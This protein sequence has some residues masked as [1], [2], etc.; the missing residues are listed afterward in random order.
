MGDRRR[1]RTSPPLQRI[2]IVRLGSLGD[3][4]HTLPAAAALREAWPEARLDWVVD[5]RQR[6][7]LELVPILDRRIVLRGRS[8]RDW[9]AAAVALRRGRYDVAIDFQGLLKSALLAR[10]SGARRVVGFPLRHLRERSARVFYSRTFRPGPG[11]VIE[12]NLAL[13]RGLGRREPGNWRTGELGKWFPLRVPGETREDL[14]WH[15]LGFGAD[16]PYALLNPGAAWPNKRW[17]PDRFAGLAA[18]LRSRQALRSVVMWGP[19]E[20]SLARAVA[21]ASDGA[22]AIAPRTNMADLVR[23]ARGA[24]VLVSGDTGPL[25]VAAAVGT[26][27]VGIYGPTDPARNGP[28]Q[29]RDQTLSRVAECQCVHR[30]RCRARVWCLEDA[31]IEDVY[32]LV[33]RRLAAV[34]ADGGA[35]GPP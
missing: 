7:I 8:P 18:R 26:P 19:G 1:V 13:V 14:H 12:K 33:E 24:A 15:R 16:E 25:H 4:I 2:L 31:G 21:E 27:I 29:A 17:P 32:A 23:L 35:S 28:W 3:I 20:E 5:A 10:A 34:P 22:A 6:E 9:L 30:R 11:H